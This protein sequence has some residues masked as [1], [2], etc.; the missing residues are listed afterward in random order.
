MIFYHFSCEKNITII[1]HND[2]AVGTMANA[3]GEDVRLMVC[4]HSSMNYQ[5]I[6]LYLGRGSSI[7]Y[8]LIFIFILVHFYY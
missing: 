2:S 4:Q 1:S 3:F 8:Y 5:S 6:A 7:T